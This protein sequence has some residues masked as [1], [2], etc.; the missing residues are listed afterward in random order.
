MYYLS[1]EETCQFAEKMAKRII[2]DFGEEPLVIYGLPRG[3]IS[4]M[5]LLSRYLPNNISFTDN[6]YEASI[7]VEDIYDTGKTAEKLRIFNRPIYFL[8]DKREVHIPEWIAFPWEEEW[9][10]KFKV[11]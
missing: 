3:G 7:I 9:K 8:I 5:F 2:E 4:T 11:I 1:L 6:P 10:E